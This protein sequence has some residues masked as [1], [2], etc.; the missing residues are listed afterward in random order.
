LVIPTDTLYTPEGVTTPNQI[1]N[2]PVP[3]QL[4]YQVTTWSRQ[5][6]HDRQII[7]QLFSSGRLP[8]R[9]G[10]LNIPEDGTRRRLDLL[11]FS[12]RDTTEG[13]KRLFSNVY[14]IRI[15]AEIFE[16]VLVQL[17]EVTHNPTITFT[18]Q[19]VSFT[20]PL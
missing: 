1:V 11:G 7:E 10:Y 2:Y 3:V 6:R 19:T 9:F 4:L 16:D 18:N 15:S 17:Y 12:K 8:F 5:P 13:D 20:A 14:N